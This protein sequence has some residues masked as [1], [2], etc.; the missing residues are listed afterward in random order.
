MYVYI[1]I[2]TYTTVMLLITTA[3]VEIFFRASNRIF[4]EQ[5]DARTSSVS[6][7]YETSLP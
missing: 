5:R 4:S 1:L 2:E 7:Y 6:V 3:V